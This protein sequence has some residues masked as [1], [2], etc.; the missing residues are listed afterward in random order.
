MTSSHVSF[1]SLAS[2]AQRQ[3]LWL[4]DVPP[5][6]SSVP[7]RYVRERQHSAHASFVLESLRLRVRLSLMRREPS[8]EPMDHVRLSRALRQNPIGHAPSRSAFPFQLF[9]SGDAAK[10]IHRCIDPS[11]VWPLRL[12]LSTRHRRRR[13]KNRRR[14]LSPV[15][16]VSIR[17]QCFVRLPRDSRAALAKRRR[18]LF[19][20]ASLLLP[21]PAQLSR[22]SSEFREWFDLGRSEKYFYPPSPFFLPAPVRR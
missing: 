12:M 18:P 3:P 7:L 5:S 17:R 21:I 15:L 14:I 1:S 4:C 11:C 20:A 16:R 10:R 2:S 9:P 13:R 8:R 19:V 6:A 22:G